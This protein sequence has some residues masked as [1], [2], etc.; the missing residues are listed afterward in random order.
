[1]R[2]S[3]LG[4]VYKSFDRLMAGIDQLHILKE[5]LRNVIMN[6][7]DRRQIKDMPFTLVLCVRNLS[8]NNGTSDMIDSK[9]VPVLPVQLE[10]PEVEL[11][12]AGH[13]LQELSPVDGWY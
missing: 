3:Q 13:C 4:I 1:L 8:S 2:F 12:P 5:K 6:M 9:F 11:F 10:D 7:N